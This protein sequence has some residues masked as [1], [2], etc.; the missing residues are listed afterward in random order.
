MVIGKARGRRAT[1]GTGNNV[2]NHRTKFDVP[3]FVARMS[4]AQSVEDFT[5]Q[6]FHGDAPRTA[7]AALTIMRTSLAPAAPRRGVAFTLVELLVVIAIVGIL[8]SLLLPGLVTAKERARRAVCA[9]NLRQ[10]GL[11]LQFYGGDHAERLPGGQSD[12]ENP[13][14]EHVPILSTRTYRLMIQYAGTSN[15]LDCPGVESPFRRQRDLRVQDN[16]GF[17]IGYNYLGGHADTPWAALGPVNA[18]WKSPRTL[19]ESTNT[20]LLLTDMNDWSWS[21]KKIIAP[22]GPRGVILKDRNA[23]NADPNSRRQTPRDIGGAGGHVLALHGGLE[24]R[25]TSA[26]QIHRGSKLW[27]VDGCFAMW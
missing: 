16:Y 2:D 8:A 17:V 15:V 10:L 5:F 23:Y 11:A 24:W 1:P 18:L 13:D 26:M 12:N 3:A 14:D 21:F 9:N 22:H 25:R 7:T 20:L 27:G 4:A 19:N 6:P